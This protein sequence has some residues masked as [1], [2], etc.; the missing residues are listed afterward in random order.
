MSTNE[1]GSMVIIVAVAFTGLFAMG[2]V[3]VDVGALLQ[4]RRV[5]QNGADA[6][7]LAI[8]DAC[9]AGEC[10]DPAAI[11]AEYASANADDAVSGVA[12]LCGSGVPS[13]SPCVD[14]PV[15]P[16][17]A[18]YVRVTTE[19]VASDGTTLVPYRFA[20]IFG[21]AGR[22]VRAR[23]TAAFGGPSSLT[24]ALPLT[25]SQ[26]ELD[27]Y[28]AAYTDADGNVDLPDPPPPHD[29]SDG[30]LVFPEPEATIYMHDTTEAGPDC[31]AGPSGADLPG[32]FGWLETSTGC[33]ATSVSGDWFDDST[34]VPP[35]NSCTATL[36]EQM[37]GTVVKLP[38][39]IDTNDLNGANGQYQIGP[40]AAFYVT[41]YSIVGQYKHDSLVTGDP[42]C[43][44]Q[45]TCISGFFVNWPFGVT[46]TIGGPSNG[47]TVVALIG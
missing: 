13:L 31:D 7:A 44:G 39:F 4:E 26:C 11:A 33:D 3:V 27:E 24:S 43:R 10:D 41:G 17:G 35:P 20:R 2:A 18:G 25:I 21:L 29:T 16:A 23:A 14:P 5:L 28:T 19:A 6:A 37:V 42:P 9:G 38:I 47:V 15:L 40:Y 45:A 22:N 34:G 32:G 12:D 46:G 8:A 30:L 36:M 1:Q